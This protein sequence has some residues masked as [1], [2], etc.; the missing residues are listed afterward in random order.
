[1]RNFL[2]GI[3]IG[4]SACKV[5]VFDPDGRVAAQ[6]AAEYGVDYPAPGQVEQDPREWWNAVCGAIRTVLHLSHLAHGDIAG[7]GVDGQSWSCIALDAQGELLC[8][9][10]IWMDTRAAEIC[11]VWNE[12][13]EAQELFA[14]C[15]NPLQPSYTTGKIL[16]LRQH[17]PE[18]YRRTRRILQANSYIVYRLTGAVTQDLSQGYGLHCFDM[19]RGRWDE[20]AADALGIDL[21]MLPP[22]SSCHAVVGTVHSK[23]AAQTGLKA[24]TP[25]VAGGLDAA[26]GALGAGVLR[27][28]ETQE[29]GGQAGGMS[30][31]TGEYKAHPSLILGRHVVPSRWLLQGGTVGGS[32]ALRWFMQEF[33]AQERAENANPFRRADEEAEAVAPGADGLVFLPYL[34]GERSPIWDPAA[35]GVYFGID[36]AKTRA[37]FIRATL[38]GVAFALRHNLETAL[39][40][41]APVTAMNAMGGAANSRLWTQI[42]ADVT[43]KTMRVPASDTATTLGAALLAGVGTGVYSGFEEAVGRTVRITRVQEPDPAQHSRYQPVYETYLAL[44]ENLK[45]LMKKSGGSI[46]PSGGKEGISA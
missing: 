12:R 1:M 4:T 24:G 15:G 10:P 2:M 18:V 43:G 28:G 44:Y 13:P 45:G 31:C 23:A 3:D 40:A 11:A 6:A 42:K 8:A 29:Q 5:A 32:G 7:I 34:A 16:W 25:V 38:D 9:D 17:R 41:G 37:H 46:S 19:R 27:P 39:A 20:R 26:C 33:G 21:A 36:Y 22:L 35:K 14:L 30:I